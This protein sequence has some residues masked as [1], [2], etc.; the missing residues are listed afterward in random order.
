MNSSVRPIDETLTGATTPSQNET[1]GKGNEGFIFL[2]LPPER[3]WHKVNNPKVG[4]KCR[5]EEGKFEHEPMF[6]PCWTLWSSALFV[7][8]EPDEPSRTW[9]QTWV[10]ARMPD[11]N[12]NWTKRSS[13][14]LVI[15]MKG[16]SIFLKLQN[17][18]LTYKM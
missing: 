3:S 8:C 7:Q 15:A 17:W 6:E 11:Y 12:F 9:T 5:L 14:I 10:Q 13:A 16:H 18:S 4:F 1:A 2:C